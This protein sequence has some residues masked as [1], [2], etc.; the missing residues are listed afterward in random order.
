[1]S[2]SKFNP[3]TIILLLIVIL[4]SVIRAAA[5][6][7]D[8]FKDFANFSAVGAIAMFGAAYF[9]NPLK[10]FGLTLLVLL[11]SDIFIAQ[12]SGYGFF[13]PGW[14]WTY[15]AFVLMIAV[16][17]LLLK[18][19]NVQHL[20]T[21]GITVILIHWVVADISAMYIP[22]LYPPT[23]AGFWACLVAAIPFELKFLYGTVIYGVVMFGFMA[24]YP[25]L[26][27]KKGVNA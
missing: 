11:L 27:F 22:G 17:R 26:S 19:I 18:K 20:I 21:T 7:A 23:I 25:S 1:M 6:Y 10:A 13:Y 14:Y 8:N 24:W 2:E 3:G 15:I 16:S 4:V 9:K 5:P 12:T